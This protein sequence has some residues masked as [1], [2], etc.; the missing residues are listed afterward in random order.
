MPDFF[1]IDLFPQV[2]AYNRGPAGADGIAV[3]GIFILFL[4]IL[5]TWGYVVGAT[6]SVAQAAERRPTECIPKLSEMLVA[7]IEAVHLLVFAHAELRA[8]GS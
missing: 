7:V 8:E 5:A 1:L 2:D 4:S 3:V 6:D